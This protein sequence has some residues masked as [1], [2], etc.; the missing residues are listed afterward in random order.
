MCFYISDSLVGFSDDGVNNFAWTAGINVRGPPYNASVVTWEYDHTLLVFMPTKTN[1]PTHKRTSI[2]EFYSMG[3][4][5]PQQAST[6]NCV[7]I[8]VSLF[9]SSR[10]YL[11][12]FSRTQQTSIII[13]DHYIVKFALSARQ[14]KLH[15]HSVNP[16]T[17]SSRKRRTT[18]HTEFGTFRYMSRASSVRSDR[19]SRTS[20]PA[21]SSTVGRHLFGF[22][23]LDCLLHSL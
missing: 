6:I 12:F 22:A 17:P 23:L 11:F 21:S 16:L 7:N 9:L 13:I 20:F 3:F 8:I 5:N 15:S 1:P 2:E 10:N 18:T 14:T 19:F 4:R